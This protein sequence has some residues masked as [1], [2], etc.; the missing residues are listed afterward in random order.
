MTIGIY[1]LYCTLYNE[2]I[3]IR[4]Y[5]WDLRID[6]DSKSAFIT[7]FSIHIACYY[8]RQVYPSNFIYKISEGLCC[9][10]SSHCRRIRPDLD[11]LHRLEISVVDPHTLYLDLDQRV[12]YQ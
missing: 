3:R 4:P 10:S 9:S 6:P 7:T 2:L 1:L 12:C 11:P 5:K 8:I